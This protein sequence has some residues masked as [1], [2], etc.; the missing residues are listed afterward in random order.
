LA[1]RS[2][3]VSALL[4]LYRRLGQE[5]DIMPHYRPDQSKTTDVVRHAIIPLSRTSDG[6]VAYS[7]AVAPRSA[8]GPRCLPQ[9]MVT[10]AWDNLFLHLVAAVV[11]DA[12]GRRD[13]EQVARTIENGNLDLVEDRLAQLGALDTGYWICAFC[14]N[15][16]AGICGGFGDPPEEGTD[17]YSKWDAKRRD[18]VTGEVF[19]VCECAHPKFFNDSPENCE[20]NKFDD[21]M[22]K[23]CKEVP[24]FLQLVAVD[25][26]FVLFS[27]A[28]CVAELVE[29]SRCGIGQHVQIKSRRHFDISE[30]D[31][32]IYKKLARLTVAEC[33]ASREE[34]KEAILRKISNIQEFDTHLQDLIFGDNGLL[35]KQFVGFGLLDAAVRTAR[36]SASLLEDFEGS[37]D[38]EETGSDP[39]SGTCHR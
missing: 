11:A 2:M 10:H 6:G 4:D 30:S 38:D 21:M 37:E 39:E 36:R 19:P 25:E 14:V 9:R 23:L 28:W 29:A 15:Q 35:R 3:P 22:A 34:D 18:S 27:R 20:M 17:A 7:D 33:E 1:Q 24:G 16:H 32:A 26:K 8:E 5:G 13:Y 31:M 12:M